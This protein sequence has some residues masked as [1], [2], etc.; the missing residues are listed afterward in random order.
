MCQALFYLNAG[1]T[2]VNRIDN[3]PCSHGI[4]IS[5]WYWNSMEYICYSFDRKGN[6][7]VRQLAQGHT[8]NNFTLTPGS[9]LL[10][11]KCWV[12]SS[13][14]SK[15]LQISISAVASLKVQSCLSGNQTQGSGKRWVT[16]PQSP[17]TTTLPPS[18]S[19]TMAHTWGVAELSRRSQSPPLSYRHVTSPS[20]WSLQAWQRMQSEQ[21]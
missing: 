18:H 4:H 12:L 13:N 5:L 17:Y 6:R 14:G 9:S 16:W 8:A 11:C 10:S 2:T 19:V 15:W 7:E 1:D 20:G 3:N 21:K